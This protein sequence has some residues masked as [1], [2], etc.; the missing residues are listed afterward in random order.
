MC[1]SCLCQIARHPFSRS[2]HRFGAKMGQN[3]FS[4][5]VEGIEF[6]ILF[7][8]CASLWN[9]TAGEG[10]Y[11][12]NL[13]KYGRFEDIIVLNWIIFVAFDLPKFYL[14]GGGKEQMGSFHFAK[15]KMADY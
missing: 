2:R 3:L 10:V 13:Y 8:S 6:V 4:C 9:G 12:L 11:E 7:P 15:N 1:N 5:R 14:G